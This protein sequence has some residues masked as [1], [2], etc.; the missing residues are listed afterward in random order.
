[1]PRNS[2]AY[3]VTLRDPEVD[4]VDRDHAAKPA[5]EPFRLEDHPWR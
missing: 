5:S 1:M 4:L 2:H 3:Q